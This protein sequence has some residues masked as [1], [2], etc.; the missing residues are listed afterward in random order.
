[1]R[2]YLESLATRPLIGTEG[3]SGFFWSPDGR[4]IGFFAEGKLKRIDVAGG[5]PM[6]LSDAWGWAGQAL[7]GFFQSAPSSP[8][9]GRVG[10]HNFTSSSKEHARTFTRARRCCCL[11]RQVEQAPVHSQADGLAA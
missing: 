3:A 2:K 10:I 5:Q 4:S 9:N 8:V 1:M 6:V 11:V 7:V